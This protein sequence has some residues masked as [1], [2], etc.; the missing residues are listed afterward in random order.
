MQ[1]EMVSCQILS[2][3]SFSFF[4]RVPAVP[5]QSPTQSLSLLLSE[6]E[7]NKKLGFFAVRVVDLSS[8][9][10]PTWLKSFNIPA[11]FSIGIRINI[12]QSV[13]FAFSAS[14]KLKCCV[15]AF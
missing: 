7:H 13:I 10:R 9:F 6:L 4:Q 2:R 11:I 5:P 8:W 12:S 14:Q 15:V 3:V 1:T